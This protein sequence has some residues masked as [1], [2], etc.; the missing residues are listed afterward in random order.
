[1][2]DGAGEPGV[3]EP[4]VKQEWRTETGKRADITRTFC[5]NYRQ[6][7]THSGGYKDHS[8]DF[9]NP[10]SALDDYLKGGSPKYIS[11][12]Y[13]DDIPKALH[14]CV[15]PSDI[16]IQG[17]AMQDLVRFVQEGNEQKE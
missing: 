7:V 2:I 8:V 6:Q 14:V 11:V 5:K 13:E 10:S 4:I 9:S 3:H 17:Y 16:H 12:Y 1:M 15:S